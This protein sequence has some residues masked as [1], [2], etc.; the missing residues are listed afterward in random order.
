MAM[1][2]M[3]GDPAV[4]TPRALPLP[5]STKLLLYPWQ[6]S[7]GLSDSSRPAAS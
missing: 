3:A 6:Y 7:T 1:M 5:S 2:L 4:I